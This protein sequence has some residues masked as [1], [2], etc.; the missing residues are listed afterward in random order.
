MRKCIHLEAP[1]GRDGVRPG[2]GGRRG[3]ESEVDGGGWER[4]RGGVREM[5]V[6]EQNAT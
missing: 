4:E 3:E 5:E 1:S 6:Y 2:L